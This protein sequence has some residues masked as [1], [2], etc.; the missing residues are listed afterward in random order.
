MWKFSNF[1]PIIIFCKNSVKLTFSLKSYTVNQLDEKFLQWGKF[2][3]L[4]HCGTVWKSEKY[5]A[6]QI[7]REIKFDDFT[8]SKCAILT[9]IKNLIVLNFSNFSRSEI[10]Q[11]SKFSA[12]NSVKLPVI[13]YSL[14]IFQ[15]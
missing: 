7:F 6:I 2:P 13:W 14:T 11:K 9:N 10:Y 4:P 1:S 15:H 12:N 8:A 5:P 3:K